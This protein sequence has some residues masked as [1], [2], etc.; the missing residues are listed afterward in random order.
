MVREVFG[1]SDQRFYALLIVDAGDCACSWTG[2]YRAASSAI[3]RENLPCFLGVVLEGQ[4]P[5]AS[6]FFK[7][8]SIL[9]GCGFQDPEAAF[10]TLHELSRDQLPML[11]VWDK[12]G[13]FPPRRVLQ[14]RISPVARDQEMAGALVASLHAF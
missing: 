13:G 14:I 11:A 8:H 6:S 5:D 12:A 7:T 3:R 4:H 10:S 9:N 2:A 1:A